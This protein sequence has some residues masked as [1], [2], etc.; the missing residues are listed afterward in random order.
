MLHHFACRPRTN[1]PANTH[2][3]T[4]C[5]TVA[6]PSSP[7]TATGRTPSSSGLSRSVTRLADTPDPVSAS[8]GD[9][10]SSSYCTH[11][12]VVGVWGSVAVGV[13]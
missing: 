13:G 8:S 9:S 3:H 7:S 11:V 5:L 4:R 6:C 12:V 1:T 2:T 10:A